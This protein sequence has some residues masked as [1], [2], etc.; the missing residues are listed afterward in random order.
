[1]PGGPGRATLPAMV[2]ASL[3]DMN[4]VRPKGPK[5]FLG[6]LAVAAIGAAA[7]WFTRPSGP[8]GEVDQ[9]HRL[10]VVGGDDKTEQ[11]L[12]QVGFEV[13]QGTFDEL[14]AEGG[15]EGA[16]AILDL[17]D[18]LGYGYVAIKGP[19]EHGVAL[20]VTA[21]SDDVGPQHAW[22]VFS[23]GDLGMPPKV[24]VDPNPNDFPL[25]DF[26][27]V[28]RAAFVQDRLASTLFDESRL[29]IDSVELHAKVKPA[30]E[31]R[32][33]YALLDTRIKGEMGKRREVVLDEDE[34]DPP[35][36]ILAGSMEQTA[37]VPLANGATLIVAQRMRLDSPWDNDVALVEKPALEFFCHP[38][39]APSLDTRTKAKSLRGGTMP[40][41]SSR[42]E[43]SDDGRRLFIGGE[44]RIESWRLADGSKG[45]DFVREGDYRYPLENEG[46]W[47]PANENGVVVRGVD[48]MTKLMLHLWEPGGDS[49]RAL[50][51]PGCT[52][53][54]DPVW[55]G[56]EYIATSCRYTPPQPE[57][58]YDDYD[59]YDL[60]APDQ[61]DEAEP[62]P[63]PVPE[64]MWLY[65]IRVS[66]GRIAAIPGTSI[67]KDTAVLR[68][69][70]LAGSKSLD[71]LAHRNFGSTLYRVAHEP[72][73]DTLFTNEEVYETLAARVGTPKPE[74]D[75]GFVEQTITELDGS[76]PITPAFVPWGAPV[77]VTDPLVLKSAT[78]DHG[79][80]HK[81]MAVSP[82]RTQLVYVTRDRMRVEI[83]PLAGGEPRM[84]SAFER[85]AATHPRFTANGSGV[86]FVH[87]YYGKDDQQ[88]VAR[89]ASLPRA[90]P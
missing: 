69:R 19:T 42:Y 89:Y 90:E 54:S 77:A 70:P 59:D 28:L 67:T 73:V 13:R 23:V 22:A 39:G 14:A 78:L 12:E 65:V 20:T 11:M 52:L 68:L 83:A 86:V 29:P 76:P 15:G 51:L 57:P 25:P 49:P 84:L 40:R 6:V 43:V 31:L 48:A 61:D 63:P 74:P 56:T 75:S 72:P 66:D 38:P 36:M 62:E 26:V 1:M 71:L 24:T 47:G 46:G 33:R 85:G 45:C 2:D 88:Y 21:D 53:I 32:G 10:L 50:E 18:E 64:Q 80:D 79:A 34:A 7:W 35:P 30:V 81:H 58:D 44:E 4:V 82:D 27:H 9:P 60:D 87:D 8:V 37:A 5:V 41:R 17:A 16:Q 3:S 55:L